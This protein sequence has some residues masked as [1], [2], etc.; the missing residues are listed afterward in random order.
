[1]KPLPMP[2]RFLLVP[3]GPL[4]R[5]MLAGISGALEQVFGAPPSSWPP[6]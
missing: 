5:G 4:P 6:R 2:E 3:V 1:V